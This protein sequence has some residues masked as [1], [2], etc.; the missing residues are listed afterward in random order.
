MNQ[1]CF[2]RNKNENSS[3]FNPAC[4]NYNAVG[5]AAIN[6]N[7]IIEQNETA[8]AQRNEYEPT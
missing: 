8:S 1:K 3:Y 7:K 2:Q 4:R 6:C 5:H